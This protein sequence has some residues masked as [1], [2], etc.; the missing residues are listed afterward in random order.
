MKKYFAEFIGTFVL[1][2]IAC[3]AASFTA[4][5]EGY[6]GVVGIALIFG[7]AVVAM[8]YSIGNI[9]GC[10]IN[11]AVSFGMLLSGRMSLVDFMGY[12]IGQML[13][14][15]AAG[16]AM[17]GLSKSFNAEIMAQY[18]MYGV[19]LTSLGTNGFDAQGGFLQVNVWG[20]VII[21]VFLTFVFVLTVIGV[22]SKAENS[23][24]A[25]LVIGLTLTCVHLFGIPFTGTSVNPARSFG[26][27][28][29]KALLDGDS[30]ALSQV[31]VFILAPLVGAALAALVYMVLSKPAKEA[32]VK[33]SDDD[34][35]D[36][37]DSEE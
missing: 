7:L 37:D 22:T 27:A 3:G 12:V 35:E 10:H 8:A 25:G 26:P 33:D 30:T 9:S 4:G 2:F 19:N 23:K 21:E 16:A 34:E 13:G 18:K 1:T 14:G 24:V 15:I 28:L 5:Y 6:L 29:I 36:E 32:V 20:A 31:W 17:F 11:P